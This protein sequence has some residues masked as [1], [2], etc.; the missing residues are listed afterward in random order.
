MIRFVAMSYC[1]LK[2]RMAAC[3]QRL[4]RIKTIR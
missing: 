3:S 2:N 4:T 1:F